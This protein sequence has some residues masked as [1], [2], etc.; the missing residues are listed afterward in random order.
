MVV[1]PPVRQ[2]RPTV[3]LGPGKNNFAVDW[4][5][6]SLL[7]ALY[8]NSHRLFA[9]CV[10]CMGENPGPLSLAHQSLLTLS[11]TD[12]T[13]LNV[14]YEADRNFMAF[15]E[16]T[17]SALPGD[18]WLRLTDLIARFH[19]TPLVPLNPDIISAIF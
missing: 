6:I 1:S 5:D 19:H 2:T 12:E 10:E 16:K 15:M 18:P 3:H 4:T 8:T 11:E 17:S 14:G 13:D 7:N 9:I